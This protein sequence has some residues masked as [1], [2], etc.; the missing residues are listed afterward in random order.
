MT[1]ETGPLKAPLSVRMNREDRVHLLIAARQQGI[2]VG[3]LV[4]QTLRNAGHLP[5]RQAA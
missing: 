4:R 1:N 5:E 2:T 3:A